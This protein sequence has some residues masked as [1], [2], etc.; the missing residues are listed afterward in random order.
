MRNARGPPQPAVVAQIQAKRQQLEMLRAAL[1]R[2]LQGGSGSYRAAAYVPS[3][4]N[5]YVA[6]PAYVA[7]QS[8]STPG[9]AMVPSMAAAQSSSFATDSV[10]VSV[11]A[12]I[13]P[14]FRPLRGET[15]QAYVQRF[16]G[17]EKM[18]DE[19]RRVLSKLS[20][21]ASVNTAQSRAQPSGSGA[22]AE[23][24]GGGAPPQHVV[25]NSDGTIVRQSVVVHPQYPSHTAVSYTPPGG[26]RST[27]QQSAASSGY[28]PAGAA[29]REHDY[30]DY[31][32]DDDEYDDDG[33]A[34]TQV[35]FVDEDPMLVDDTFEDSLIADDDD[36]D[37]DDDDGDDGNDHDNAG[38]G[39]GGGALNEGG[40]AVDRDGGARDG[41]KGHANGHRD[42]DG[43]SDI[44]SNATSPSSAI[45][46]DTS[47]GPSTD[48]MGSTATSPMPKGP[49]DP[50][51]AAEVESMALK[52]LSRRPT[53][54]KDLTRKLKQ[55][56]KG[57]AL[58][59]HGSADD[60]HRLCRVYLQKVLERVATVRHINGEPH[61]EL[62]DPS[63][64]DG[65][66]IDDAAA[67]GSQ[68]LSTS[69]T[70]HLGGGS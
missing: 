3:Q 54:V 16:G 1:N 66:D 35:L 34:G 23:G 4:A 28:A 68:V 24:G 42:V 38:V 58:I 69:P 18:G 48:N 19:P 52:Y 6:R 47:R 70:K 10:A 46:H 13:D 27:Y 45:E 20:S 30:G 61:W 44:M 12:D 21:M 31:D 32:D 8:Q 2:V 59:E 5:T 41:E 62:V 33:G 56:L 9:A 7:P 36:D 53:T 64:A 51:L 65:V 67:A 29:I 40:A 55:M 22:L 50:A 26:G 57:H 49:I 43:D 39:N 14:T 60:Q 15:P 25:V 37:D 17:S 11:F 63:D